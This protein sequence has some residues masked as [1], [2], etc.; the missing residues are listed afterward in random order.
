MNKSQLLASLAFLLITITTYGQQ[1]KSK[2]ELLW[3]IS[4]PHLE[5][6]SYIYGTMH[7]ADP[8]V[9][10]FSD[11]LYLRI[12]ECKNF[13]LEVHPDTMTK[14]L[15]V[16]PFNSQINEG[17]EELIQD[18][19]LEELNEELKEKTGLDLNNI[20]EENKD[21]IPLAIKKSFKKTRTRILF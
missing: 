13:A 19:E 18:D 3:R 12:K 9:F 5:Q 4:A 1:S 8:R 6:D 21:L 11:S 20:S 14:Y 17:F 2:H 7:L 10:N 16:D 15:V